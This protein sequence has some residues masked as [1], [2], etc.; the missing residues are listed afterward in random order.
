MKFDLLLLN[1]LYVMLKL[2]SHINISKSLKTISSIIL[3]FSLVCISTFNLWHVHHS[4]CISCCNIE[5]TQ[6]QIS[7]KNSDTENQN[8]NCSICHLYLNIFKN[9][10]GLIASVVLFNLDFIQLAFYLLSYS[11]L[12][13]QEFLN[14][15]PPVL[16]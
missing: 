7:Y 5:N 9:Y 6:N 11:Y 2:I 10:Y 4:E 16:I 13:P 12:S 15:S 3:I 1:L 14:R 8:A